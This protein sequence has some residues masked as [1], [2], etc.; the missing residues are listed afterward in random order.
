MNSII[1]TAHQTTRDV[2]IKRLLVSQAN[3]LPT[4]NSQTMSRSNNRDY[5]SKGEKEQ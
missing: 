3:A 1:N 4:V 5:L 2:L